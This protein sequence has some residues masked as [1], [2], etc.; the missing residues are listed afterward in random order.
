MTGSRNGAQGRRNTLPQRMGFGALGILG[1][2]GTWAAVTSLGLVNNFLLP[3]PG[4]VLATAVELARSGSLLEDVT[5]SLS[6]V[7]VGFAAALAAAVPLGIAMGLFARVHY[8]VDPLVE[9]IRPIPPIAVIPLAMLWFGIGEESKI[10][11]IA[12]G[13]FFPILLNTVAGLRSI[14]PTHVRAIQTLGA[15][16]TQVIRSVVLPAAFPHIV[17]G[18][19]LGIAMGFIVLVAAELIAAESGLGYL[20][21]DARRRFATDAVLVG[22]IV[23][24]LI[25]LLLNHLM[26]LMERRVVR[27]RFVGE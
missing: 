22:I 18:A 17:V 2:L 12:F 23:I 27:W 8:L 19:R 26:L 3:D 9:L 14:D 11:L 16:R 4:T 13:S 6:R 24:G 10:F 15:T 5:A 25:G 20:I 1:V 7:V 21:E